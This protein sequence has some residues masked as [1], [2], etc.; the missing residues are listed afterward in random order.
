MTDRH[1]ASFGRDSG[2]WNIPILKI[3]N[4]QNFLGEGGR[5]APL[6]RIWYIPRPLTKILRNTP[7]RALPEIII[8][9][10]PWFAKIVGHFRGAKRAKNCQGPPV[11][12]SHQQ[13]GCTFYHYA[14]FKE[15]NVGQFWAF[16]LWTLSTEKKPKIWEKIRQKFREGSTMNIFGT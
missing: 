1:T 2:L 11:F 16:I 14:K 3:F 6:V 10:K 8:D 12:F 9:F 13:L 7:Y 15:K 5:G 4:P